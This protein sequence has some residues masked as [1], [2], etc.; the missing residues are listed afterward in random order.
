MR[1]TPEARERSGVQ[2]IVTEMRSWVP[3]DHFVIDLGSCSLRELRQ[4]QD[5]NLS[6]P[7]EYIPL[8]NTFPLQKHYSLPS[9]ALIALHLSITT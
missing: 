7:L 3:N 9:K 8:Q 5:G 6:V 2:K 4:P 1:A